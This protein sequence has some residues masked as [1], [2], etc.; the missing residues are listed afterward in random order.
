MISA[1]PTLV[2]FNNNV[3]YRGMRFHIQTEDSG[4]HRPHIITHLFADGGHVIKSLRTDYTEVV[5]H[6][7][8]P[9]LVH[10]MMREQ[11]RAMALD[12]RD[13]KLDATIDRL[14]PAEAAGSEDGSAGAEPVSA[15]PPG[16]A[17][18]PT[19]SEP[20]ERP[21]LRE[22]RPLPATGTETAAEA[23]PAASGAS[24]QPAPA[25]VDAPRRPSAGAAPRL[26]AA[27][28]LEPAEPSEPAVAREPHASSDAAPPSSPRLR[29][30]NGRRPAASRSRERPEGA[31]A[32]QASR[33]RAAR[34]ASE[35]AA[36][37]RCDASP[38]RVAVG[39]PALPGG[40]LPLPSPAKPR[41]SRRRAR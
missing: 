2:G 15:P 3:R 11:H 21:L 23:S 33:K 1:P 10:R 26:V 32:G 31:R 28:P 38:A 30:G 8:R 34:P 37:A 4:I 18:A 13:G 24:L 17:R 25:P 29:R 7:E 27:K 22:Q 35:A 39:A 9:A 12:L 19:P 40:P 36:T 16:P 14:A 41:R 6:P 5:G 20:L